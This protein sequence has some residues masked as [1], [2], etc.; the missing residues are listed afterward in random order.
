MSLALAKRNLSALTAMKL[1][2]IKTDGHISWFQNNL[3]PFLTIRGGIVYNKAALGFIP[4]AVL[5]CGKYENYYLWY[6][7]FKERTEPM[8]AKSTCIFSFLLFLIFLF[9]VNAFAQLFGADEENWNKVFIG[10]KK[11]NARLVTLETEEVGNLKSQLENLL[12]EIE[13]IK[14]AV[15]QLQGAIELNKSETLSGLNKTNSKLDDLEGE[16]KDQVLE[17]IHQQ[18]KILELSRKGQENLKEGLA[19][20][21]EKFEQAS[22]ANFKDFSTAN[23]ETLGEVVNRLEAQSATTKKG[24]DDT[25]AL[26]RT[27]VIPTIADENQKNRKMVLE[28]LTNANKETYKS[29]E[30]FSAKNQK[31]N[32]KLIEILQESLKQGVDSKSLL[33]SI[34]KDMGT[35]Q[36]SLE[37][38]NKNIASNH[39]AA[40]EVQKAL[41]VTNENLG[42]ADE[43]FNK[44]IELS[45]ELAVH[46]AELEAS[47]V[48]QL[49]DSAQKED[50]SDIK[51]DL[52]N[53][54]LSR[55][56]EILKTIATEQ[57]KLDPLATA[58]GTM[59]KEQK[60][61]QK[62]QADLK[63]NQE[64][65]QSNL[66]NNQKEIKEALADLRR[67]ANVNISRNDD[68]KKTLGQLSP[69]KSKGP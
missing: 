16:V 27:D 55:L 28:N 65:I 7:I 64:Q 48:G 58:L 22:R 49:K 40:A 34:K 6:L 17:K 20:D 14:H 12:R 60:A 53:E 42:V 56:I 38:A 51:V 9:P 47:V 59:Q 36:A 15:P 19:Q 18:N 43:K 39:S 67:K 1:A 23:Q 69:A 52:A 32:Q 37:A 30:A 31:L 29:L 57:A 4:S 26:F 2:G 63:K 5:F 13:E 21:I 33:D 62:A 54:K 66:K 61:L 41:A 44:L 8:K 24:F 25:I 35:T 50:A 45:T 46:S 11:I 3:S 68:I 10:L